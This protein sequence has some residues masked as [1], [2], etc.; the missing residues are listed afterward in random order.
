M[1]ESAAFFFLSHFVLQRSGWSECV[2]FNVYYAILFSLFYFFY[3]LRKKWNEKNE[4]AHANIGGGDV[5]KLFAWLRAFKLPVN[6]L[7]SGDDC[8][9]CG[10]LGQFKDIRCSVF[11]SQFI[12]TNYVICGW[13]DDMKGFGLAILNHMS[14]FAFVKN[15]RQSQ[16]V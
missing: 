9:R 5:A 12:K 16:F 4:M 8:M 10:C 2:I 13:K 15:I 14:H 1:S 11:F 3:S 6:I 7:F